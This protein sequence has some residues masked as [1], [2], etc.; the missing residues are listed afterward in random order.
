MRFT[1]TDLDGVLLVETDQHTD[2]RGW[3]TRVYCAEEFSAAG[4]EPC[5]VQTNLSFTRRRGTIRGLHYQDAAAP[6]PKLVRCVAGAIY[7][8]VVDLRPGSPT[9]GRWIAVELAA[10]QAL[11]VPPLCAHGFQTLTDDVLVLYQMGAAYQPAAARGVRFDDPAL[12]IPWPL[13][14]TVISPRDRGWPHLVLP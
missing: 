6:E 11:Y 12:G 3:F 7:D 4:L 14:V 1:A 10:G 2:D 5:G 8:V 13:P 9:I